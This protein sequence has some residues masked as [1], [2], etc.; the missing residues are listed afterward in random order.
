MGPWGTLSPA[1]SPYGTAVGQPVAGGQPVAVGGAVT[2]VTAVTS[3]RWRVAGV[4]DGP[5][6]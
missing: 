2:A 5:T 1:Q 6:H 4:G 3:G